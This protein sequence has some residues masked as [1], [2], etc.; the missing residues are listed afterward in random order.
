MAIVTKQV[1]RNHQ[2]TLEHCSWDR[3]SA[4]LQEEILVKIEYQVQERY[5][6]IGIAFN[7][8]IDHWPSRIIT[9]HLYPTFKLKRAKPVIELRK[10]VVEPNLD[11]DDDT[12]AD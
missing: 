10:P 11:D 4:D 2:N 3:I 7:D 5:E 12:I 1:L 6:R 9:K 8:C